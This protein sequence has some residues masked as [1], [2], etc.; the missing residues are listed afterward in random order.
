MG[1][2]DNRSLEQDI[3]GVTLIGLVL[4]QM[5][6][7]QNVVV[8]VFH[9]EEKVRSHPWVTVGLML[10]FGYFAVPEQTAHSALI[11]TISQMPPATSFWQTRPQIVMVV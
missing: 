9:F 2:R 11:K 5:K 3:L 7:L 6:Y 10:R 8:F 1:F 4:E